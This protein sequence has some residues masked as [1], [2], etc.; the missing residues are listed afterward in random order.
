M[1]ITFI[2]SD[3][4]V[5][6]PSTSGND[7]LVGCISRAGLDKLATAEELTQSYIVENNQ[8]GW[9]ER[10]RLLFQRAYGITSGTVNQ[11][12]IVL[13]GTLGGAGVKTVL[14]KT[15]P[16]GVT[17][18][19]FISGGSGGTLTLSSDWAE[20]WWNVKNFLEYGQTVVIGL[21]N[22]TG[23]TGQLGP[24][25]TTGAPALSIILSSTAES[26]FITNNRF[27]CVFQI[28]GITNGWSGADY[29]GSTPNQDVYNII[30]ILK[31]K[32]TPTVGIVSA[33]ITGTISS[34][35]NIGI[36][37]N[38]HIIAIAGKK[39]HN[40]IV[41]DSGTNPVL[42]TT[43]L[44]PDVAG[45]V[46]NA[47][48]WQ[49]PAGTQRGVVRSVVALETNFTDTQIGHLTTKG[50]NYCKNIN[51]FGTLLLNDLVTDQERIN[52]IRTINEVKIELVPLAYEVLFEVNDATIRSQFVSRASAR[53]ES[54]RASGAIR[55]FSIICDESNNTPE[56]INAGKFVAKVLL[57]FGTLIRE[58]E[59]I[60][61]RGEEGEGGIIVEGSGGL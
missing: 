48:Y 7:R 41:F 19:Q 58:V 52:I 1:P 20:E 31:S 5:I 36:T 38:S 55:N 28:S 47:N 50:V 51:G 42:L 14:N 29:S 49:S 2:E 16:Y 46:A 43:H 23:F 6:L 3:N 30:E 11:E 24:L 61:S 25:G 32:E 22:G 60:V 40:G 13:G 21:I 33:G 12:A 9:Y 35:S 57:V 27:N 10:V 53:V 45:I 37:S 54:I 44:A 4:P 17:S 18:G 8:N 34:T 26:P 59:I 15:G 56:V 39:K